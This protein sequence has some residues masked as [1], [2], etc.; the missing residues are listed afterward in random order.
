MKQPYEPRDGKCEQPVPGIFARNVP[1]QP[2]ATKKPGKICC[3]SQQ[4]SPAQPLV[5]R[6]GCS[7]IKENLKQIQEELH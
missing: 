7:I 2:E 4:K 5:L 1:V 6:Q 3:E